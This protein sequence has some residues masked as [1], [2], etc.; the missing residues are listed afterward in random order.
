LAEAFIDGARRFAFFSRADIGCL[1]IEEE[2]RSAV[3]NSGCR[4]ALGLKSCARRFA[5]VNSLSAFLRAQR[6]VDPASNPSFQKRSINQ[7]AGRR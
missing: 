6:R 5:A 4:L 2:L 3:V 1:R 7:L